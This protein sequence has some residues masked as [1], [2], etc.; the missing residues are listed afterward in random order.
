VNASIVK[1]PD[2][3]SILFP[4]PSREI[5]GQSFDEPEFFRDLNLDQI[6]QAITLKWEGYD[7]K[8]LFYVVV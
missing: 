4:D 3:H 1:Y 7:L 6:V 2:F 5:Q 8:Q